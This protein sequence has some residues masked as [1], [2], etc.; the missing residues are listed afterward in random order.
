M[1]TQRT[2]EACRRKLL[3]TQRHQCAHVVLGRSAGDATAR[4]HPATASAPQSLLTLSAK[5]QGALD[6]KQVALRLSSAHLETHSLLSLGDIA[7]SLATTR[8]HHAHRVALAVGSREELKDALA[9]VAQRRNAGAGKPRG[10]LLRAQRRCLSSQCKALS[11]Q[12]W[13]E[14]SWKKNL[15]SGKRL[16]ACSEAIAKEAGW[17]LV[18]ELSSPSRLEQIEVVQP[19]CFA[20]GVSLAALWQLMGEQAERCRGPQPR[21]GGGGVRG[22]GPDFGGCSQSQ[23]SAQQATETHLW[24]WPNGHGAAVRDRRARRP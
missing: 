9:S 7:Y 24:A 13:A 16:E 1:A 3:W 21:R 17:S 8:T 10:T 4:K 2:S 19:A 5:T 23:L 18:E 15:S 6:G 12:E 14:S 20:M 22:R 11:G